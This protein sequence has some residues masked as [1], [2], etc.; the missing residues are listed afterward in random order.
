MNIRARGVIDIRHWIEYNTTNPPNVD[1]YS[2]KYKY[3]CHCLANNSVLIVN[4]KSKY[5]IF[6]EGSEDVGRLHWC[7]RL[8]YIPVRCLRSDYQIDGKWGI[9]INPLRIDATGGWML[10]ACVR[11]HGYAEK[12]FCSNCHST[13][14]TYIIYF[15]QDTYTTHVDERLSS[16]LL[17]CI[18]KTIKRLD[19]SI[20]KS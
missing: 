15:L 8:S 16:T 13:V 4:T 5:E 19:Y 17:W 10:S 18:H 12:T 9:S 20:Q 6:W 2:L 7:C 1:F 3:M 11:L 14:T